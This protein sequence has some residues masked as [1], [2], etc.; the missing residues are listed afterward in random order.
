MLLNVESFY[1]LFDAFNEEQRSN[2]VCMLCWYVNGDMFGHYQTVRHHAMYAVS[3]MLLS[4]R[5]ICSP[6]QA[7][8][9]VLNSQTGS[10]VSL[11]AV[12]CNRSH[13]FKL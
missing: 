12:A 1:F 13:T 10:G 8:W 2:I 5:P 3:V 7:M 6:Y 9:G 4:C 11:P